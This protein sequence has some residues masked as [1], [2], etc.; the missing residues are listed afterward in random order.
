MTSSSNAQTN[1]QLLKKFG[2]WNETTVNLNKRVPRLGGGSQLLYTTGFPNDNSGTIV[3]SNDSA[4]YIQGGNLRPKVVRVWVREGTGSVK[5]LH[6]PFKPW[7]Q[8]Y[9]FSFCVSMHFLQKK[10]GEAVKISIELNLSD[11]VLNSHGLTN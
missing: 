10:W 5:N 1:I 7:Y 2:T 8:N 3:S 9:N 11:H 4:V 6:E